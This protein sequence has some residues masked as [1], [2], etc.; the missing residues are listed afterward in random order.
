MGTLETPLHRLLPEP[1]T[2]TVAEIVAGF[3]PA[4]AAPA[5]RPYVY[6]N[7]ALTIDGHDLRTATGELVEALRQGNPRMGRP[8]SYRTVTVD[9]RSAL[10]TSMSNVSDVTGETEVVQL[11]TSTLRDGT[12]FHFI[13]VA[14]QGDLRVYQPVFNRVIGS[15]RLLQ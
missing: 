13:A 7:F 9:G 6:T 3:D 8:S 10:E 12:M 15:V 5:D 4:A 11:V 2:T 14:P 1:G